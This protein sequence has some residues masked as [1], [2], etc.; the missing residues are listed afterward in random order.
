MTLVSTLHPSPLGPL[1]LVADGAQLTHLL[2]HGE[3]LPDGVGTEGTANPAVLAEAR[4]QLDEYFAGR[5][6][7]FDL[8]LRPRGT[9]FQEAVWRVLGTISYGTTISYR[10][11]A[12]RVDRPQAFRAVGGAN[13]RNPLPIVIPCHRVIA[14]DGGLG[15]YSGGL[16]R[17]TLLLRLEGVVPST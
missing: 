12:Q 4:R 14:A 1:T 6:Q 7:Q 17:K 16:E 5:R 15:G 2:M 3:A 13:G 11:L 8:P 9:A 10:E